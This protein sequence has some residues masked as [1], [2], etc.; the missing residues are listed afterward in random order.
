MS[1]IHYRSARFT[2]RH[3]YFGFGYHQCR[4]GYF[5][6]TEL[7]GVVDDFRKFDIP[8]ETIWTD[9]DYMESYRDFTNDP[10]TFS[11]PE[12]KKFLDGLHANN[13]HYVPIV[14]SAIYDPNPDNE[15]DTYITYTRMKEAGAI[16]LNPDGSDYIGDVWPGYTVFPDWHAAKAVDWWTTEMVDWYKRINFDGI[17]IDMS[18]VSSFCVGSCGSG[19]LSL[20]PVHPPFGLPGEPG[21]SI[22]QVSTLPRIAP[23]QNT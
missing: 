19:N 23:N 14:D 17:W 8:L 12:G 1:I 10:A 4:W 7:Q 3:Q 22:L 9:I 2:N 20:N 21:K 18:E 15:T 13:Q 6:W 5:N 16:L 11:V